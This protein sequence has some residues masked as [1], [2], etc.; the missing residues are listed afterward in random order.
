M[1]VFEGKRLEQWQIVQKFDKRVVAR[2]Q[3]IG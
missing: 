2:A 3:L 1:C